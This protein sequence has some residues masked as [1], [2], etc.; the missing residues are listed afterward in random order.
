MKAHRVR[1]IDLDCAG[2]PS[3]TPSGLLVGAPPARKLEMIESR[4]AKVRLAGM[5]FFDGYG[6]ELCRGSFHLTL[7][8]PLAK[9]RV[10]HLR[11]CPAGANQGQSSVAAVVVQD[12]HVIPA[13]LPIIVAI[14]L[15]TFSVLDRAKR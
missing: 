2:H 4:S 15:A 14:E 7:R 8:C 9:S 6:R 10:D 5:R 3:E 11:R 1:A 13:G 12:C